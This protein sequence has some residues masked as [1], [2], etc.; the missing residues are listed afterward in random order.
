MSGPGESMSGNCPCVATVLACSTLL[1]GILPAG[2]LTAR[3]RS[4]MAEKGSGLVSV[5]RGQCPGLVVA[6]I[7]I[8]SHILSLS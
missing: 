5:Q 3:H 8:S 4:N 6:N 1:E 7:L 2:S